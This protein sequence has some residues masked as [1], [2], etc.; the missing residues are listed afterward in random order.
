MIRRAL[1]V[2]A[3]SVAVA[4]PL[5]ATTASAVPAHKTKHAIAVKA[6][7]P[8]ASN[9]HTSTITAGGLTV[10]RIDWF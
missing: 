4:I 10:Q 9:W 2:A 6:Q 5:S 1:T 7:P 3:L 8:K